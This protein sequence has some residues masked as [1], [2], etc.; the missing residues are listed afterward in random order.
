[1]FLA[2]R[3]YMEHRMT[4]TGFEDR[5]RATLYVSMAVIAIAL[6]ATSRMWGAGGLGALMWMVLVGLG[7]YGLVSVF[8]AARE[9]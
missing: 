5:T 8:R 2:Y 6:V 3:L 1:M 7:V 4:L 9:Y